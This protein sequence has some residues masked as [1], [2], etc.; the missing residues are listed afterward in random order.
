MNIYI[1]YFFPLYFFS[2]VDWLVLYIKYY[3]YDCFNS[4][5]IILYL[6][7]PHT[8]GGGDLDDITYSSLPLEGLQ[9]VSILEFCSF[10]VNFE[11]ERINLN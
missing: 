5:F 7:L 8:R 6:S 10:K 4:Y 9:W 1:K 2:F 3:I 11:L